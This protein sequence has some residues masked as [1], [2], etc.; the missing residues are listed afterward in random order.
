VFGLPFLSL[1]IDK[2]WVGDSYTVMLILLPGYFF[3]LIQGP[4]NGMLW[5]SGRLKV[6]MVCTVVEALSNLALSLLLVGPF[7]I[8]GVCMGTAIPMVL[9]RGCVFPWVLQ[10]ECGITA[11]E[12]LRMQLPVV[13]VGVCYF[14]LI[15]GLGLIP[16]HS[17]LELFPACVLSTCIFGAL[18]TVFLPEVRSTVAGILRRTSQ[19]MRQILG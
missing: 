10:H 3:G 1:W 15:V 2:P 9:V 17:M 18:L 5:G 19:R 7:G 11:R 12:F 6:Q 14:A 13:T 4:A 8:F 16:Y